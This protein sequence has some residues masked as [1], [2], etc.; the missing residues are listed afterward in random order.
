M[1]TQTVHQNKKTSSQTYN[2]HHK[3]RKSKWV[4]LFHVFK[5][6]F[7]FCFAFG[8]ISVAGLLIYISTITLPDFSNF[9]NRKISNSTQIF[10]RTGKVLLYDVHSD[11]KRIQ[12]SGDKIS[13]YLKDATIAIEDKDF[14]NH[15]GIRPTSIVRAMIANAK[16]G[17][18][19]QGG[20][21]IDQQVIKNALLTQD[22]SVIRKITE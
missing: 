6:I 18:F 9:A 3:K 12:I 14:Y 22:K 8:F 7:L 15:N 20:S 1:S 16:A 17:K 21:T 2:S 10:D 5:N 11:T 13:K 19:V 4:I